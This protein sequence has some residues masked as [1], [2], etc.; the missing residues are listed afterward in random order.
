MTPRALLIDFYGVLTDF[1]GRPE[2]REAPLLSVVRRLRDHGVRTALVSNVE[3]RAAGA[4]F[5]EF[6]AVVLSGEVGVAKPDPEIFRLTARLL[7][8]PPETCVFVDDLAGNARGAVTAGMIGVHHRS[9]G[10][11]ITELEALFELDLS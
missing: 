8:L 7:E 4:R 6:D 2:L 5:P 3:G 1:D 11:T 9:V 10:E